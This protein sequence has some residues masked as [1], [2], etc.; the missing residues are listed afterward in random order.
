MTVKITF[1]LTDR[2]HQYLKDKVAEGIY[3]ST[4]AAVLAAVEQMI[5]DEQ[6]SDAALGAMADEIRSRSTDLREAFFDHDEVFAQALSQ[7]ES[8]E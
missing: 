8:G 6:A 5:E 4:S 7:L 3:A 1:Y 2:H